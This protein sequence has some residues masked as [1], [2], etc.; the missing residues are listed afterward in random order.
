MR[1]LRPREIVTFSRRSHSNVIRGQFSWPLDPDMAAR[2]ALAKG[3][4]LGS[5]EEFSKV[6]R[7]LYLQA[8]AK[9]GS[10]LYGSC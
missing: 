3:T 1:T 9:R 2:F 5:S 6:V 4:V 7:T 10:R 8:F